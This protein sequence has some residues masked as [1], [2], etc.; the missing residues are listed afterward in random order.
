MSHK[1]FNCGETTETAVQKITP[2]IRRKWICKELS[3]WKKWW[4]LCESDS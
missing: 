4:A 2:P 1:C 3:C